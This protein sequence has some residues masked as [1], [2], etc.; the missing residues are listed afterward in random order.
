MRMLL[1]REA[2]TLKELYVS[3]AEVARA[4]KISKTQV[5]RLA[6]AGQLRVVAAP[7]HGF[8]VVEVDEAKRFLA[9]RMGSQP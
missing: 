4:A 5:R 1:I 8:P 3:I 6:Q 9:A 7:G 2:K